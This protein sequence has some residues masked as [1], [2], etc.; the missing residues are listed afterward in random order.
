MTRR[1]TK[2]KPI[3]PEDLLPRVDARHHGPMRAV[4][5][6]LV[7]AGLLIGSIS[8]SYTTY[9]TM[10]REAVWIQRELQS[11]DIARL[12]RLSHDI[13]EGSRPAGILCSPWPGLVAGASV[14]SLGIL[15]LA[16]RRLEKG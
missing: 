9:E 2:R 5:W 4:A 10:T 11:Q 16:I 8:V 14:M 6:C 13:D 7:F 15:L 12:R 1:R 3:P